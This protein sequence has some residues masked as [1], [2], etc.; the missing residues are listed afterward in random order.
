MSE[1]PVEQKCSH[2]E[3]LWHYPTSPSPPPATTTTGERARVLGEMG[4]GQSR[5]SGAADRGSVCGVGPPQPPQP[6]VAPTPAPD[7]RTT[8]RLVGT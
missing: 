5:V 8:R 6:H 3:S 1:K 4:T 2:S 7:L